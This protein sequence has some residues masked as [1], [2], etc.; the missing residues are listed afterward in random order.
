MSSNFQELD[1]QTTELGELSLRRRRMSILPDLDIFEIKLND[2][3][4]MSSLFHE[5]ED[6][7]ATLAL[8]E[9]KQDQPLEV[10]VGGLGLG[11]TAASALKFKNLKNLFVVEYLPTLIEWHH[12]ELVP[13]ST[14]LKKDP[15]C[16]F[17][18]ADFFALNDGV[19]F[20]PKEP[21]K[22]FDAILLDIDHKPGHWLHPS[23]QSFYSSQGLQKLKNH[24]VTDGIFSL[25]ADGKPQNSFVELLQTVFKKVQS[26]CIEFGNPITR[27]SSF[28]TVYIA[29]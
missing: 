23:N 10:V 27:S 1:C 25:W 15:R 16:H 9:I 22:K 11:Y 5:A 14:L 8:N 24:L 12:K 29:R 21:N 17:V 20:D 7:L 26:H 13:M 2:E 3:Y 28:G 4:L 19:G 6:Q 18:Q